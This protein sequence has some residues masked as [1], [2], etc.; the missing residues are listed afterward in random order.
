MR[1]RRGDAERDIIQRQLIRQPHRRPQLLL[2]LRRRTHHE[3]A[4]HLQPQPMRIPDRLPHLLDPDPLLIHLI[5]NP[6]ARRFYPYMHDPQPCLLHLGQHILI[7][8]IGPDIRAPDQ[9]QIRRHHPLAQLPHPALVQQERIVEPHHPIRVI[10]PLYL[11]QLSHDIIR[12]P[13]PHA[14]PKDAPQRRLAIR[15]IKRA[16]PRRDD[17]GPPQPVL[18]RIKLIPDLHVPA[19]VQQVPGRKRNL[20]EVRNRLHRLPPHDPLPILVPHLRHLAEIPLGL[21]QPDDQLLALADHHSIYALKPQR[22]LRLHRR[23]GAAGA[24]HRIAVLAAHL[25]HLGGAGQHR[26]QHT[27]PDQVVA[28]LLQLSLQRLQRPLDER[29]IEYLHLM[30]GLPQR[31]SQIRHTERRVP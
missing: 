6:L 7:R 30:P 10:L 20:V 26:G 19:H 15:A 5:E 27:Y 21:G 13:P 12:R 4:P 23:M 1:K 22:A 3:I 11:H 9:T 29:G 24:D 14:F 2:G 28:G 18:H 8:H 31:S 16:A 17:R 25:R